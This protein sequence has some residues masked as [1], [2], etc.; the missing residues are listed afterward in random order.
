MGNIEFMGH[1]FNTIQAV[2]FQSLNRFI[3]NIN[4]VK[5]IKKTIQKLFI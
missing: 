3:L 2:F 5:Y 4:E 1:A